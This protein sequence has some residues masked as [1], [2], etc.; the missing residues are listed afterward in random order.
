MISVF[1]LFFLGGNVVIVVNFVVIGFMLI[2]NYIEYGNVVLDF[3][4]L[5]VF[6]KDFI[7]VLKEVKN[8]NCNEE[9]L[10]NYKKI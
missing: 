5:F 8:L 10:F 9:L 1:Q 4:E 2:R 6:F 3:V 7:Y